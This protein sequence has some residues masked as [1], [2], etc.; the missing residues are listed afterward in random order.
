MT[1]FGFEPAAVFSASGRFVSAVS[2]DLGSPVFR[3]THP[4]CLS[5][6]LDIA[7]DRNIILYAGYTEGA[8]ALAEAR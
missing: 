1:Q 7:F 2:I 4:L 3:K 6:C 5:I 8:A